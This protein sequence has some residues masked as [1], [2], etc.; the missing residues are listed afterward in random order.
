MTIF[1]LKENKINLDGI[2]LYYKI[3]GEGKPI[4][5]LHGW[6][7][8]SSSWMRTIEELASNGF[9]VIVPDL[10]GFGRTQPPSEVWGVSEYAKFIDKFIKKIQIDNFSV[11]GHSFGG[12]IITKLENNFNKIIFCDAAIIR[13]E[14]FSLRQKFSKLISIVGKKIVSKN[15][16]AYKFFEKITYFISGTYD[17]YNANPIMKDIFKKVISEDLSLTLNGINKPC[18]IIW[19]DNDQVTPVED[20]HFINNKVINSKLRLINKCG[21]NPHRTNN[22]ELNSIIIEFLK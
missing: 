15:F 3:A 18:L 12:G 20:A 9:K 16:F 17:Y 10:P 4:L 11:M 5:I 19:G 8:G 13:K 7:A 1:E 21:H 22:E 14:R 2:D 6:G